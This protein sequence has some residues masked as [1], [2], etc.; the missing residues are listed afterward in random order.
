MN[1]YFIAFVAMV[2]LFTV[3]AHAKV[4]HQERSMYRNILV[5]DTGQLRCLKFNVKSSK[6]N[7]SCLYKDDPQKLVFNY[8]KL[9]F[10][11]LLLLS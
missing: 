6:T 10:S 5:E 7:Q 4:V 9:L 3:S 2:M 8:T 11:S 1:K